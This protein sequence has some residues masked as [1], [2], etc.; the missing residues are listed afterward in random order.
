MVYSGIIAGQSCFPYTRKGAVPNG[1]AHGVV[2]A[3]AS[4]KETGKSRY[5]RVSKRIS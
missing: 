3:V 5:E 4:S 2:F 1:I